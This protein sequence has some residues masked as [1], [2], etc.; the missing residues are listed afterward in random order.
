MDFDDYSDEGRMAGLSGSDMLRKGLTPGV[1]GDYDPH[2]YDEGRPAAPSLSDK[3]RKSGESLFGEPASKPF[4]KPEPKLGAVS[5]EQEWQPET[6]VDTYSNQS[7]D[8]DIAD[9]L[10][11]ADEQGI[12]RTVADQ[13]VK[14]SQQLEEADRA[15]LDV[16]DRENA[17]KARQALET[18]WG[19]DAQARVN[20][21]KELLQSGPPGTLEALHS[22][23]HLDG[24]LLLND[25]EFLR[26]MHNMNA[27]ASASYS[28]DSQTTTDRRISE[29][30]DIMRTNRTRYN[31]DESLQREL[32]NLYARRGY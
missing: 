7:G 15:E 31:K 23:R 14:Y 4:A 28:G 10:S 11:Y 8:P 17:Q 22:A 26:W 1:D 25:P 5:N 6:K 18:V 20:E 13:V 27:R 2:E 19:L 12:D 30:E 29:I 16:W 9:F 24:T 21:V 3:M 32:R